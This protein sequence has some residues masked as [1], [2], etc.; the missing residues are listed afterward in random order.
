MQAATQVLYSL[1][2]SHCLDI[3]NWG[4]AAVIGFAIP[5]WLYSITFFKTDYK[6]AEEEKKHR[7]I[8]DEDVASILT[9]HIEHPTSKDVEKLIPKLTHSMFEKPNIHEKLHLDAN[10]SRSFH[11]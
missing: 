3:G 5:G 4:F 8:A 6:Q 10:D 2:F 11:V 7:Q 1:N 9:M